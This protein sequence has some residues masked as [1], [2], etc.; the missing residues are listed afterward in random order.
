MKF[1]KLL[2][3]A[4][5]A[6]SILGSAF[7]AEKTVK[8]LETYDQLSN[9]TGKDGVYVVKNAATTHGDPTVKYGWA[10]Y[11]WDGTTRGFRLISKKEAIDNSSLDMTRYLTKALYTKDIQKVTGTVSTNAS[12]V[13]QCEARVNEMQSSL[14]DVSASLAQ[15]IDTLVAN[16]NLTE[17]LSG[18]VAQLVEDVATNSANIQTTNENVA[19]LD[20]RLT[21]SELAITNLDGKIDVK[22]TELRSYTDTQIADNKIDII[23]NTAVRVRR[24]L[25]QAKTYAD[26]KATEV[27]SAFQAADTEALNAAAADAKAKADTAEQNAK[28]YADTKVTELSGTVADTYQVKGNYLVPDDIEGK[29][30][31]TD[32]FDKDG[33]FTT[34]NVNSNGSVARIWNEADGGGI[35]IVDGTSGVKAAFSVHEGG[36]PGDIGLYGQIYAVRNI[37]GKSTGSRL[38]VTDRGIF[39]TVTNTYQWTEKDEVAVKGDFDNYQ[40]KGNY[41]S[42]GDALDLPIRVKRGNVVY[43]IDVVDNGGDDITLSVNRE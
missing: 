17:Q 11:V 31:K 36:A 34:E 37:G 16:T 8:I 28:D 26:S 42:V 40:P 30:N 38:N 21:A 13:A 22:A 41:I 43:V 24:T 1:K 29:V 5:A 6:M 12:I 4:V 3:C 39:Y 27:T 18:T 10:V 14:T 20:T 9:F 2:F 33:L 25:D 15:T 35:Q 19:G 32:I 23:T 7:G